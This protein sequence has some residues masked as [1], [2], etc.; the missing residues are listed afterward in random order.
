MI[1]IFYLVLRANRVTPTST[2]QVTGQ[3][4]AI[5][6]I[7][8]HGSVSG[9]STNS[10]RLE[11]SIH[12][13]PKWQ[14]NLV[15]W[16]SCQACGRNDEK[17][18]RGQSR[19]KVSND[20]DPFGLFKYVSVASERHRS[21]EARKQLRLLA[22]ELIIADETLGLEVAEFFDCGKNILAGCT[23]RRRCGVRRLGHR[24]R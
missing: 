6:R 1:V 19:L 5:P 2:T 9:I 7:V 17:D 12:A 10:P 3:T 22:R 18:Q 23:T 24:L 15:P 8:S 11:Q 21:S 13:L 20:S 14:I 4:P 16:R